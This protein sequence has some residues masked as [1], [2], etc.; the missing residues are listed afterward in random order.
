LESDAKASNSVSF[1]VEQEEMIDFKKYLIYLEGIRESL[2]K[3]IY[4]FARDVNRH[5]LSSPHS[6]HDSWISSITI[7]ENRNGT[8]PFNP[9]PSIEVVL[10]GPMHDRDIILIYSEIEFYEIRGNKNEFNW[11]DTFHGDINR[12]EIR[13]KDNFFE[14][15]IWLHS[16]S[17]IRI[18]FN[19]FEL[20]EKMH[21]TM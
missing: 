2:P 18:V 17:I 7:R 13:L 9:K 4:E 1:N 5:S 14:H 8:R 11:G 19:E 10:L 16:D 21:N 20:K 15:A 12:H 3:H 6:L